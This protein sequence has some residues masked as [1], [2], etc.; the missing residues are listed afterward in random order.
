MTHKHVTNIAENKNI[1]SWFYSGIFGTVEVSVES[2]LEVAV[3]LQLPCHVM[4]EHAKEHQET[5]LEQFD[6][7]R[8]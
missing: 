8:A 2:I 3:P 5:H 7:S 4:V 1:K 6:F